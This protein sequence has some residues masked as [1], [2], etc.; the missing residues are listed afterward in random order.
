[1]NLKESFRYQ[2]Y[3]DRLMTEASASLIARDHC[4]KVVKN[5]LK[6]KTNPEATDKEEVVARE[7]FFNNDYVMSFMVWLIEERKKLTEA[8]NCAKDT[9]DFDPDAAVES[10]KFRQSA[11]GAIKAMLRHTPTS[12]TASE[13]DYKFNVEGNQMPYVY[14]VEI[15]ETDDYNR[16]EAKKLLRDIMITADKNSADVDTAMVNTQV[17]YDPLFDVNDSF[18]DVMASFVSGTSKE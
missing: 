4:I 6:S 13:R 7:E 11:S 3:L 12:R 9:L 16:S 5:H 18:E 2:N 15:V 8:I 10:N 1:M 17:E 14:D